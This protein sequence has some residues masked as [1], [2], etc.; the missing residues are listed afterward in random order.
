MACEESAEAA[1][2]PLRDSLRRW[3]ERMAVEAGPASP[4]QSSPHA[5][6]SR[7]G[8]LSNYWLPVTFLV[9][10]AQTIT[11]RQARLGCCLLS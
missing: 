3:K 10:F 8:T 4:A 7:V 9:R 2:R 5:D 1:L 6:A 11:S